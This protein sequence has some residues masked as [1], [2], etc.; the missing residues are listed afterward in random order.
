MVV[1]G[2]IPDTTPAPVIVATAVLVL[3]HTPPMPLV[4]SVVA[5]SSHTD[6]APEIVPA[7][8]AGSTVIVCAATDAP[9]L[10]DTA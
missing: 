9:Q 2:A 6:V 8:G 3:L 5:E 4:V 7:N 1:P 10:L